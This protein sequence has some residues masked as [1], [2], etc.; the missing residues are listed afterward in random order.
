MRVNISVSL[1]FILVLGVSFLIDPNHKAKLIWQCRRGML[2]L[3]LIL[4]RFTEKQFAGF[5]E[6]QLVLFE[7]LLTYPDPDLYTW[8]MGYGEPETTEMVNFVNFLR[9]YD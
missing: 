8:L 3:D 6:E 1:T 2:E 7:Q 4:A 5:S 9:L